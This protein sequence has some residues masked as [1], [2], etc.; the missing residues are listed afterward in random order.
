MV[1]GAVAVEDFQAVSAEE[2][3]DGSIRVTYTKE[4]GGEQWVVTLRPIDGGY[5]ILSNLP[6]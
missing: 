4:T 6:A 1:T 2:L 3:E 5:V